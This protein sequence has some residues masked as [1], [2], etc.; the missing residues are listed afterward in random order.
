MLRRGRAEDLFVEPFESVFGDIFDAH[1][2]IS[3]ITVK[4]PIFHGDQ[5]VGLPRAARVK[6]DIEIIK[7]EK[8]IQDLELGTIFK[9]MGG[10]D[11]YL[12]EVAK[13]VLVTGVGD[14]LQTILF[15]QAV[16]KDCLQ[17]SAVVGKSTRSTYAHTVR[18]PY[19]GVNSMDPLRTGKTQMRATP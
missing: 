15:R 13:R 18:R 6:E 12:L 17:N 16:L 3:G 8:L 2:V 9:A 11:E 1:S 14:D 5:L 10:D 7:K 19:R 4:V